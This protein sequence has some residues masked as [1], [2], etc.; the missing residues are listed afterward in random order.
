MR[1]SSAALVVLLGALVASSARAQVY[2]GYRLDRLRPPPTAG[3]GLAVPMP[4]TVGHLVPAFGLVLDYGHEPLVAR[5]QL[6][7][8]TGVVVSSRVVAHVLAALG[9]TDRVELHLR[10]PVVFQA[11]GGATVA[12]TTFAAPD[13]ATVSDPA[14]GGSV[15]LVGDGEQGFHLGLTGEVLF[16]FTDASGYASDRE[17]SARGLLTASVTL[18]AMSLVLAAGASYRPERQLFASRSASE[19]DLAL[20]LRVPAFAG[21]DLMVEL[22]VSSGLRDDLFFQRRGTSIEL[23]LGGRYRFDSGLSLEL[24]GGMG[25]L[26]APGTPSFRALAGLRWELPPAGPADD[27]GDGLVGEEDR[28]PAEAEDVDRW[29]DDDGCPDPDDDEDGLPD[30]TDE[31]PREPEDADGWDDDDGCPDPDNDGDGWNDA[32]DACRFVPGGDSMRGCPRTIRVEGA[33][34]TLLQDLEFAADSAVLVPTNGIVLDEI[35]AVMNLDRAGLRW[36]IDVRPVRVSRRDDGVALADQRAR[37]VR[38]SLVARRVATVRL[39]L[40]PASAPAADVVDEVAPLVTL[41]P[42]T[43]AAPEPTP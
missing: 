35:A 26:R 16:P 24:G 39:V 34:I 32:D 31:C 36:R 4:R 27:D 22:L 10:V 29:H 40:E 11:G 30:A 20:G 37:A 8:E 21:T 25:F 28:C 2:D 5:S 3:D 15:R 38:D 7:G 12:G 42:Y 19:L 43:G 13:V 18:P 17:V 9:I 14:L 23:V 41:T 1:A 33:R 6:T